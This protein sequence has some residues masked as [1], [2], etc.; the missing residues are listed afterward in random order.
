MI[1]EAE[2]I[3]SAFTVNA[4]NIFLMLSESCVAKK[5]PIRLKSTKRQQQ[6]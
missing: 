2:L 1:T 3:T 6:C 4:Q 5:K